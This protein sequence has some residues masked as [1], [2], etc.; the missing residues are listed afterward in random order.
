MCLS[1]SLVPPGQPIPATP[2]KVTFMKNGTYR[3]V[4]WGALCLL[5]A[6]I[7]PSSLHAAD[8]PLEK[9]VATA[10]SGDPT[11]RAT[12][13]QA[14][15]TRGEPA[16]EPLTKLLSS[17]SPAVRAAA[18]RALGTIGPAAKPAVNRLIELFSDED[19]AVRRQSLGALAAIRPGPKVTVPLF[20]KLMQDSDPGV[21]IRVMQAIADAKQAAVPALIEAL[22]NPAATYW[23]CLIL[24]D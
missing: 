6:G 13:I 1:R 14:L 12:A 22:K 3:F 15:G 17:E 9:L 21:R 11:A 23:A 18:A 19:P 20:V 8:E 10:N 5:T 2:T 4:V 24:R 7:T 16:V